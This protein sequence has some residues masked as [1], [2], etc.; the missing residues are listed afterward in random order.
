MTF[1]AICLVI[2]CETGFCFFSLP[3]ITQI[4]SW[5]KSTQLKGGILSALKFIANVEISFVF[6]GIFLGSL[7]LLPS[8]LLSQCILLVLT[9][10]EL[11][12]INPRE[13]HLILLLHTISLFALSIS[14][15]CFLTQF[16]FILGIQYCLVLLLLCG[17]LMYGLHSVATTASAFAFK[18]D[19]FS[20]ISQ[21]PPVTELNTS[22]SSRNEWDTEQLHKPELVSSATEEKIP[23]QSTRMRGIQAWEPRANHFS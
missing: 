13:K 20:I 2:L 16:F 7:A 12:V 19:G 15:F 8:F 21:T 11:K 3:E 14:V 18:Q 17:T 22:S 23:Q 9:I 4:F 6:L 1:Y 10:F 5:A